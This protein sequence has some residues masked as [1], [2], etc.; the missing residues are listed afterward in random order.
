MNLVINITSKDK[1]NKEIQSIIDLLKNNE[2][3]KEIGG[4]IKNSEIRREFVVICK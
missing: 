1:Y 3:I 2:N 4:T